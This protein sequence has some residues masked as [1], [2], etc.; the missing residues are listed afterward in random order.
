MKEATGE[1]NMTVITIVIIAALA[2]IGGTVLYPA[3]SSGIKNGTCES[4]LGEGAHYV[5]GTSGNGQCCPKGVQG[6][7]TGCVEFDDARETPT[8][9]P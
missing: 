4:M 6:N 5:K 1:L 3:I 2:V 8:N 7:G 9:R